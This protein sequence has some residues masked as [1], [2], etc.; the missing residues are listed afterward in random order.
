MRGHLLISIDSSQILTKA[1]RAGITFAKHGGEKVTTYHAV[2]L[3]DVSLLC[4]R[5][6]TQTSR[7]LALA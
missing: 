4:G 2:D 6:R 7:R 3:C 5:R 1:A